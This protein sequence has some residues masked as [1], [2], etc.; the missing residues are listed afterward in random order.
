MVRSGP[1]EL[2]LSTGRPEQ[3]LSLTI[4]NEGHMG[5]AIQKTLKHC[6]ALLIIGHGK[7]YDALLMIGR[8]KLCDAP[9]MTGHGKQ[10][11]APH[12]V[13]HG[14]LCD[15]SF[16]IKQGKQWRARCCVMLT[17]HCANPDLREIQT[18]QRPRISA[19]CTQYLP[20]CHGDMRHVTCKHMHP[21]VHM[22]RRSGGAKQRHCSA[23]ECTLRA[24]KLSWRRS[25]RP[26]PG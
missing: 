4:W 10:C 24:P 17:H 26:S 1:Q 20:V 18:L 11:D 3:G 23:P 9:L 19:T 22:L 13:G 25:S 12:M 2:H 16:L 8:G 7:Q 15:A 21:A 6:D 14:K 5:A